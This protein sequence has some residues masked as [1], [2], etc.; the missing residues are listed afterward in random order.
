MRCLIPH[1]LTV[2][3]LAMREVIIDLLSLIILYVKVALIRMFN[4]DLT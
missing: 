4:V 3:P 1:Q 2:H